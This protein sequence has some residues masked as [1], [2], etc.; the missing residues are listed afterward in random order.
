[1]RRWQKGDRLSVAWAHD[2]RPLTTAR[3][4]APMTTTQLSVVR[5]NA[6]DR[7]G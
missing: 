2:T 1:L 5:V 7:R 6:V 3:P 4:R